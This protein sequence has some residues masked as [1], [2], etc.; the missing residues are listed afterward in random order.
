MPTD[1]W[2]N[3]VMLTDINADGVPDLVAAH[4]AGPRVW[5]GD[6][7]GGW[8]PA[9][10]GLPTPMLHGLYRGTAV[11]DVNE[12]G[13]LD[14]ATANWVDG[15]EVYL[16]QLDGSWLKTPDVFPE[17][18]GGA[19]GLALGDA[20]RDGHLDIVVS[21]RLTQDVGFVYGVFFL[22]GDGRG[23]WRYVENSGLPRTG[24]A[25]T[26]GVTFGDVNGDGVLDLAAGSG[27]IVAT[28]P[29]TTK[30]AIPTRLLVWCSEV[31]GKTVDTAVA[32]TAD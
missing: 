12:D 1:G 27:G 10:D 28:D 13:R 6:G 22:H 30:P 5:L 9:S 16:Q 24:L 4:S 14:I 29:R 23:G 32:M 7:S 20:D 2:G 15:P 31:V 18:V 8:I 17:S 3:R 11:G 25:F 26:W 21:G 19:V